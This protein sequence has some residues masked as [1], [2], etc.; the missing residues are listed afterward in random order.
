MLE[1]PATESAGH[2]LVQI[3]RL[4]RGIM[5]NLVSE[6]GLYQGQPSVLEVL[7]QEEGLTHKELT[8][9]L[10]VSPA[11]ISNTIKRME[12]AGFVERRQDTNDERVS[13]VYLTS[14]GRSVQK[15]VKS[16][17]QAF[18]K[19]LLTDF[20]PQEKQLLQTFLL[21]LYRNL[22]DLDHETLLVNL[23]DH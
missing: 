10:H 23:H 4:N 19:Q 11:T 22:L 21:R 3:C 12:K 7:W 1:T 9:R 17:W 15:D 18:E 14:A 13:R 6:M 16:L 20:S 8:E 2:L 5:H